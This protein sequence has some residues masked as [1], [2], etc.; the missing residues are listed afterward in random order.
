[1]TLYVHAVTVF[2][3]F[4]ALTCSPKNTIVFYAMSSKLKHLA[5]KSRRMFTESG[6]DLDLTYIK[7]NIVV[8]GFPS[9]QQLEGLFRNSMDEVVRFFD[10]R[11]SDHYKVYN[12]CSERS[13]DPSKFHQRVA[14]Y[15]FEGP[16]NAP[17]F[18]LI[19][20]FCE[21]MDEWLKADDR[22]VAVVHCLDGQN[23]TGTMV[24]AYLLHDR[25]FDS[26]LD[27]L[28]FF[29]EARSQDAKGVTI[30]S[31]RR[32]VQYYGHLLRFNLT[33]SPKTVF[34][35]CIRFLGIP[36][37]QGGTCVPYFTIKVQGIKIYISKVYDQIK[38]TDSNAALMLPQAL[39]LCGDVK[40]EFFHQARFGGKENMFRLCINTFFIDMHLLQQQTYHHRSGI[41]VHTTRS[42]DVGT[43]SEPH[44]GAKPQEKLDLLQQQTYHHRS[45][46][47]V[48]T[49]RS[50]D[51]GTASE[52]HNEAKPQEKLEYKNAKLQKKDLKKIIKK[53]KKKPAG[54]DIT[55]G[56]TRVIR[57]Q[58]S[59]LV[60]QKPRNDQNTTGTRLIVHFCIYTAFLKANVKSKWW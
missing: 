31:Q 57:K 4:V 32:Y 52:P 9:E 59:K 3:L 34:L 7:P 33:Y 14:T 13:Y 28:Q 11:H 58:V 36:A 27:A 60:D 5:S 46:I 54:V 24:C 6:F 10:E 55:T 35:R 49:T 56:C 53:V 17:P 40:I 50:S 48:H 2:F 37:I 25:L 45:G 39:P 29:G 38:R 21:D 51:V 47:S 20:P 12:L 16:H 44:N 23:R 22:N 30:P 15:P 26:T 41:S 8:M 42:S 43:A 18:E 1:M 19:K